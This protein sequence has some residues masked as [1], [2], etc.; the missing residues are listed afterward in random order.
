MTDH[1]V[2]NAPAK[3]NVNLNITGKRD[4]GYHLL[5]S[6]VIFAGLADRLTISL[7]DRDKI[8]ITGPMVNTSADTLIKENSTIHQARDAFR[9]A[10]GWTTPVRIEVEKHIP[11]AA[12]LGGGSA[13][14]AATLRGM[15]SLANIPLGDD[16]L[17]KIGLSIGADVPALLMSW[18]SQMLRMEGIGERLTPISLNAHSGERLGILLANPG[19]AVS[20]QEVFSAYAKSGQSFSQ[21]LPLSM[22]EGKDISGVIL[23]GNDLTKPATAITPVISDLLSLMNTL[24][25]NFGG[26]G[27]SMSGSGGTCFAIFPTPAKAIEA[28]AAFTS[29]TQTL[30]YWSW[31]GAMASPSEE[32]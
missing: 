16:A 18:Q 27:A 21:A 29:A 3:I 26:Y 2:I 9:A 4:D 12:G 7:A 25:H 8:M 31:S 6:I 32:F 23:L 15:A 5:D 17:F 13:D 11:I 20:T 24:S 19:V 10:T 28:E 30:N 1:L 22:I 14:A